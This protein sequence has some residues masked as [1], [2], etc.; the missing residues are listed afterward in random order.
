[1]SSTVEFDPNALDNFLKS[2]GP[3]KNSDGGDRYEGL[4]VVL[5]PDG[6]KVAAFPYWPA[7][8]NVDREELRAELHKWLDR[9][10]DMLDD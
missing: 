7:S 4:F 2:W 3:T 8:E 6:S 1:L 10:V 5:R 9:V